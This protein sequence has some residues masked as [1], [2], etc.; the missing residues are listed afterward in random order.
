MRLEDFT[1]EQL[2]F[3]QNFSK[4]N[5]QY[6]Q[7]EFEKNIQLE[8]A[9]REKQ[10]PK[11]LKDHV[12]YNTYI[13][14]LIKIESADNGIVYS[15]VTINTE[16]QN[17]RFTKGFFDHKSIPDY[18]VRCSIEMDPEIY[19]EIQTYNDVCEK[20]IENARKELYYSLLHIF[21]EKIW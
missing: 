7:S 9:K 11:L 2:V 15:G 3:L 21:K 1:T 17:Y 16:T 6:N 10:Y 5:N 20:T 4:N 14:S 19:N 8:L 18:F 12:Y 13:E